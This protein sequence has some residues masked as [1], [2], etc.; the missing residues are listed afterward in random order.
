MFSM[1]EGANC[2]VHAPYYPKAS[3]SQ[4]GPLYAGKVHRDGMALVA[5]PLGRLHP[6]HPDHWFNYKLEK[7]NRTQQTFANSLDN[8]GFQDTIV[9]VANLQRAYMPMDKPVK[10][11]KFKLIGHLPPTPKPTTIDSYNPIKYFRPTEAYD[12]LVNTLV[13]TYNLQQTYNLHHEKRHNRTRGWT[14]NWK[15]LGQVI[16]G[17]DRLELDIQG[18]KSKPFNGWGDPR[19]RHIIGIKMNFVL[20]V[21]YFYFLCL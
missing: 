15:P 10:P 7:V 14:S 17:N 12:S 18:P 3:I 20:K 5:H 9:S 1:C 2:D 4:P 16:Y 11:E 13:G 21:N 8:N 19:L 6:I